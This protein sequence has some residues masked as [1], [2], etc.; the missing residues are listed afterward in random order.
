MT[1]DKNIA[2][3]ISLKGWQWFVLGVLA[4]LVVLGGLT[5][6]YQGR[7]ISRL[8]GQATHVKLPSDLAGYD[9]IVSV[10]F[11]KNEKGE[12]IK[13]LTYISTDG[14]LHSQEY[15]DWGIF[16]GEIIWELQGR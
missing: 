3:S 4:A 16:Q 8:T 11:H 1:Q 2:L 13:D 14:K 12:T 15:N 7:Q 10:S 9:K 6:C 5:G